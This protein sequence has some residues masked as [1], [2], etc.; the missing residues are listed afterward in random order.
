MKRYGKELYDYYVKE[1]EFEKAVEMSNFLI[2]AIHIN[3]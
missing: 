3:N 2:G 1:K